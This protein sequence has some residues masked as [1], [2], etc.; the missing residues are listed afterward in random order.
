MKNNRDA[1]Q[2]TR[3]YVV[4]LVI[5]T[6]AILF[7]AALFIFTVYYHDT[8]YDYLPQCEKEVESAV[9]NYITNG[10]INIDNVFELK[11]RKKDKEV[12]ISNYLYSGTMYL[13]SNGEVS[14]TLYKVSTRPDFWILVSELVFLLVILA[15]VITMYESVKKYR[16]EKV[17]K[18]RIYELDENDMYDTKL[19]K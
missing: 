14:N 16:D 12:S 2:Q 5:S 11:V 15:Y 3:D 4:G 8:Y 13:D 18:E 17:R 6:I 7:F 9:N 1:I 10:N 19:E